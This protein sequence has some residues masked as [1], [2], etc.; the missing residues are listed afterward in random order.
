MTETTIP[1]AAKKSSSTAHTLGN[2]KPAKAKALDLSAEDR[3]RLIL[4]AIVAFRDGNFSVRLPTEWAA[5]DGRIAEAFNQA[6]AQKQRISMEITRL[7]ATV[8]KEGRLKQ[9][10]SLPGAI[11]G[12]AGE[13]D[14]IDR[15]ST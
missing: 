13:G 7:S 12:G 8:G 10:V 4:G 9:R 14:S 3:S 2:R 15:E 5:T 1:L 6:S 11:G